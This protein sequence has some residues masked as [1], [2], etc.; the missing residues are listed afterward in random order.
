MK[1]LAL[2]FSAAILFAAP[3]VAGSGG[4][5]GNFT[6]LAQA[7]IKVAGDGITIDRDRD[8]VRE[9]DRERDWLRAGERNEGGRDCKTVSIQ[10]NG[11]TRS[12]RKCD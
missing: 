12:T 1:T 9:R 2:A 11:S 6:Q 5:A 7:D 3:A 4:T 8:R 10:E